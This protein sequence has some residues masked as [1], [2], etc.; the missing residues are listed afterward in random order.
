M[1]HLLALLGAHHI[2]DVSRIRVKVKTCSAYLH[3]LP[4]YIRN[5]QTSVLIYKL[6]ILD[7]YH[8]DTPHLRE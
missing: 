3:M 5:Y 7:T 1:C 6:L 2:L 8:P 4:V